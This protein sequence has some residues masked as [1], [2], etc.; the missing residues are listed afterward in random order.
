MPLTVT[1]K[2]KSIKEIK[3]AVLVARRE[4]LVMAGRESVNFFK[5]RFRFGGWVENGFEAWPQRKNDKRKGAALLV[6]TG[7]LRNSIRV[8]ERAADYIMIGS[9]LPYAQIHNEG[10]NGTEQVKAHTRKTF[11]DIMAQ[12]SSLKTRKVKK[13]KNHLHTGDVNVKAHSR[14]MNMPKRHFMG[15]SPFLNRRI[16]S[17]MKYELDKIR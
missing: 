2:G 6:Q 9:N 5:D 8:T 7:K 15:A 10:F 14:K 11:K 16:E 1:L 12:A 13:V 4:L 17:V 3:A